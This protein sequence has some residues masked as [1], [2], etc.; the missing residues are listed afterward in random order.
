MK[1][2]PVLLVLGVFAE[3]PQKVRS[4]HWLVVNL[5]SLPNLSSSM[6]SIVDK[7]QMSMKQNVLLSLTLNMNMQC[8][9]INLIRNVNKD[10][11]NDVT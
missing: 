5:L 2:A 10:I 8:L 7:K 4:L 9:I 1:Q 3:H 11:C 6:N